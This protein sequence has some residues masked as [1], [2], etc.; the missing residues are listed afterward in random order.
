MGEQGEQGGK[1][2]EKNICGNQWRRSSKESERIKSR[3]NTHT[4]PLCLHSGSS[5][6]C[7]ESSLWGG[8]L[9]TV[10]CN[11]VRLLEESETVRLPES[12]RRRG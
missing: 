7:G 5:D 12:S 2:E 1:V 9:C 3:F 8:G 11:H 4:V 10:Q 6:S